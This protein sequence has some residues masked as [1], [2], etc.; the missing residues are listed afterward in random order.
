MDK[1]AKI[2]LDFLSKMYKKVQKKIFLHV[3]KIL[4]CSSVEVL[5]LSPKPV[6]GL[7]GPP[8]EKSYTPPPCFHTFRLT[9]ASA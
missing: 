6:T 2:F 3:L 8:P 7:L 5:A 9:Q 1:N 4:N